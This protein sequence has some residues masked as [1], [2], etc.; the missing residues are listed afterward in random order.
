MISNDHPRR[1]YR[2][3]DWDEHFETHESRKRKGPLKWIAL[4]TAHDNLRHCRLAK[5]DCQTEVYCGW[6][7]LLAVSGRCPVRGLLVD[8]RGEALNAED[9]AVM[10]G[11]PAEVF[12]LALDRLTDPEQRIEWLEVVDLSGE[13]SGP[14]GSDEIPAD[15]SHPCRDLPASAGIPADA[16]HV[17]RESSPTLPN[18][19]PP[20][21][22]KQNKTQHDPG[23][24]SNPFVKG[25]EGFGVVDPGDAERYCRVQQQLTRIGV[26]GGAMKELC[27]RRDL[28]PE[29]VERAW[30]LVRADGTA[31]DKPALLVFRLR[32]KRY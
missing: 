1:A 20:D 16:S 27:G 2:V 17:C 15:D 18:P 7:L 12:E 11:F 9:L 10:T 32:N 13:A 8:D 28:T 21:H 25:L 31:Q 6:C 19:T 29:V 22:T 14:A 24:G 5:L 3:R 23:L 4:P 30:N 26:G